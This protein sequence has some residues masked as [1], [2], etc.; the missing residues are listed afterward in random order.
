MIALLFTACKKEGPGEI[1]LFDLEEVPFDR[2]SD[3]GFFEGEISDLDPHPSLVPYELSTGLFSNYAE[4]QRFVYFPKKGVATYVDDAQRTLEFP[5]GTVIIKTFYYEN[6]FT[7]PAAGKNVLETRLL[8]RKG[9]EWLAAEYIWLDDQSD[10]EYKIA[11]AQKEVSWIHYDG[12]ERNTLYAMPNENECKGCHELGNDMVLIGPKS[13]YLNH[14]YAYE[15]G[16]MNQLEKWASLGVLT[17]LPSMND[18]PEAALWDDESFTLDQRAR[19]YLDINC[20]HCHN[21]DGPANNTGM[22]LDWHQSD[23]T[24]LGICKS[25]VAAGSGTG[26]NDYAILPGKPDESIMIYRLNSLELDVSM[27]EL[28]RSVIHDEG[29]SLLTEWVASLPETDNCQ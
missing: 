27:P 17:G 29:L 18:V 25:P 26:G 14:V 15:D 16:P 13:R 9:G 28:G 21:A 23:S 4:K 22:F 20:A 8:I 6:D 5:E 11:G 2:L 1:E 19:A 3:Y 10:A 24:K 7:N 12:S